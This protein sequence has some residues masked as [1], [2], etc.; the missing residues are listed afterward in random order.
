MKIN[1]QQN[2]KQKRSD[3]Q[4]WQPSSSEK[5][6][7]LLEW[8]IKQKLKSFTLDDL[9]MRMLC[10]LSSRIKKNN[11]YSSKQYPNFDELNL[12]SNKWNF[13]WLKEK[14]YSYTPSI[15]WYNW[16]FQKDISLKTDFWTD[17]NHNIGWKFHLNVEP[18][19]VPQISRYLVQQNYD[20]KY[21][22]GWESEDGKIFTIYIGSRKLAENLAL[23]IKNDIWNLLSQPQI[24]NEVEFQAGVVG[25]FIWSPKKYWQYWNAGITY[26]YDDMTKLWNH[27]NYSTKEAKET[28]NQMTQDAFQS[29]TYDYG[30]YFTG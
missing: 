27:D 20:H 14:W 2:L 15:T 9:Q 6:Y 1:T 13:S 29:L 26:I 5:I 16:E 22:N 10:P 24:S 30:E 21:L 8:G 11:I 17:L 4:E 23:E 18:K 28:I 19:N 25:R 12:S 3:S 7:S